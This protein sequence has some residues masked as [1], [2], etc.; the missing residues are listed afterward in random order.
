[1]PAETIRVI[2]TGEA[3]SHELVAA[4]DGIGG[5]L[6]SEDGR[7]E[8]HVRPGRETASSL[9]Q[10]FRAVGEWLD[11]GNEAS[12][13]IHFADRS[14]TVVAPV[15]GKPA[16]ATRFLLERTIQLH[17]A[18]ESRVVI[19]QAK[20]MLAER[21]SV[22]LDEAFAFLRSAARSQGMKLSS[23]AGEVVH[24]PETPAVLARL[25]G[26]PRG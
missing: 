2:T 17:A 20:G 9:L 8:V 14:L 26:G 19:E 23:L 6:F 12:C 11:N 1:M 22:T 13:E 16:D 7:Y 5:A 21:L 18:L 15:N 3:R 4:L 10:F 24:S 25:S